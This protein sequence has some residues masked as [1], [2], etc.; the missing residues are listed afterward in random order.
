M[1]NRFRAISDLLAILLGSFILKSLK[2][3]NLLI[4]MGASSLVRLITV[5]TSVAYLR[6]TAYFWEIFPE[7]VKS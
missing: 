4:V 7:Q 2:M 6:T 1:I 5:L 3:L